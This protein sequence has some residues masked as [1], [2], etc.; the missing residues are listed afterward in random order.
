MPKMFKPSISPC[1]TIKLER[2]GKICSGKWARDHIFLFPLCVLLSTLTVKR[3]SP[4][5]AGFSRLL[6]DLGQGMPDFFDETKA[7]DFT[8]DFPFASWKPETCALAGRRPWIFNVCW[9]PRNQHLFYAYTTR[10]LNSLRKKHCVSAGFVWMETWVCVWNWF[11]L[12]TKQIYPTILLS[13]RFW[14]LPIG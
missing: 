8:L 4:I 5:L 6:A 1:F 14:A 12:K 13:D 11:G 3:Y 2:K 7:G 10:F 9:W